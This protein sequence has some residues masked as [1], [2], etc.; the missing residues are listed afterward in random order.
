MIV[1]NELTRERSALL[2][3]LT[4]EKQI[5]ECGIKAMAL[6]VCSINKITKRLKVLENKEK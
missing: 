6:S 3:R 5:L 1:S 2:R 4:E